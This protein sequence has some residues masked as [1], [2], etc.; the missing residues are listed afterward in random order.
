MNKT[1]HNEL[2]RRVD[3]V[4]FYVLDPF[5]LNK[6]PFAREEHRNFVPEVLDYILS[7]KKSEEIMN[8]LHDIVENR[9]GLE[10][11]ND[12]AFLVSNLLLGHKK[13][14]ECSSK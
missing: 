6:E 2:E 1:M 12:F 10:L 7:E 11:N 9:M 5:G 14:I 13:A 4:L 8:L 3:E